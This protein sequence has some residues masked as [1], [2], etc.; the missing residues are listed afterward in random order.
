M[1]DRH[2]LIVFRLPRIPETPSGETTWKQPG[3][4]GETW[5]RA[6]SRGLP[7][8]DGLY[9]PQAALRKFEP[10]L[11][12]AMKWLKGTRILSQAAQACNHRFGLLSLHCCQ[13]TRCPR[14]VC[15]VTSSRV[16]EITTLRLVFVRGNF[17]R[18]GRT[19]ASGVRRARKK[20]GGPRTLGEKM[21]Y[22]KH[23]DNKRKGVFTE[24]Q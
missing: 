20:K 13:V 2:R 14:L 4:N 24:S 9:A 6:R 8:V 21:E 7:C 3:N 11:F 10:V 19:R 22:I 18:A 23:T 16:S 15:Q 17:I 5:S 1:D 12:P